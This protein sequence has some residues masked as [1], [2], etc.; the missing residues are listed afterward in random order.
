MQS[1]FVSVHTP[2]HAIPAENRIA[3][4]ASIRQKFPTKVPVSLPHAVDSLL[5]HTSV[6]FVNVYS[7]YC[8]RQHCLCA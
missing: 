2:V 8:C 1:V 3:E 4:V 7:Q 6:L 5:L